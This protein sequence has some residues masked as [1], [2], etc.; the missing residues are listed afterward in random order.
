M[1]SNRSDSAS[2]PSGQQDAARTYERVAVIIP[3]YNEA[4]SIAKVV[5]DFRRELPGAQIWVYDNNSTDDT[6]HLAREAGAHV[7]REERRGKGNVVRSMMRDIDA[8]CYIM[9]D[10]D[11]TY[12]AEAAPEMVRLVLDDGYD[13]VNGDRLST[14]YFDE[15]KS[16][17]HGL[18]NRLVRGMIN[19]LFRSNVRDIMTGYRAMG[20]GFTK[21]LPVLSRGFELETEM[22]IHALDKN[23][24]LIE[25][26]IAYRDRPEGSES[27]INSVV[28]GAKVIGM[29]FNLVREYRPL[30]FFG[31]VGLILMVL[32][33]AFFGSVVA[34][35]FATHLV[36]RVPTLVVSML[37]FVLGLLLISTGLILDGTAHKAR[38]TFEIDL[39]ELMWRRRLEN[40][41]GNP[42]S[43]DEGAI[44]A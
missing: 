41:Q 34:E 26:P 11:D 21:T 42:A 10:G 9:V 22:T 17:L 27:K 6:A 12:P 5:T 3:C 44:R 2:I 43:S 1:S 32:G 25:V 30:L 23:M 39:N 40:A 16:V 8:D 35:F 4:I 13:M 38:K 15:N 36:P 14:T 18:G 20:F 31:L 24:K 37:L 28:D 29:I 19:L 33:C 7:R